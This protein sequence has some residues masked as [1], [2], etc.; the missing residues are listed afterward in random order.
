MLKNWVELKKKS[1]VKLFLGLGI[2]RT[3]KDTKDNNEISEWLRYNDLMKRQI[4]AG[5]AT[6]F[7][8]GFVFFDYKSFQEKN[9]E[10]EVKNILSVFK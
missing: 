10:Q 1:K 4:E 9:C 7:V 8:S 2:Y 3:G 5:R 6:G